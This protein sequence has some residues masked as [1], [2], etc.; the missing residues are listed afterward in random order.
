MMICIEGC[1]GIGKT[2]LAQKLSVDPGG[3]GIFEEYDNNPFLK[4]FY[5]NPDLF[6]FHVQTTFLCLQSK[7]FLKASSLAA[8]NNVFVDF[9]PIKSQIFSGIV[10]KNKTEYDIIQRI[11]DRL[12]SSTGIKMLMVY[13]HAKPEII[14]ERIR[15]RN[16]R[17]TPGI[18]FPYIEQIVER[19]NLYFE[20]Y[21]DPVLSIDMN[22]LDFVN[23]N[24]DWLFVKQLITD[25]MKD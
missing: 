3:Y 8:S 25:K 9:H 2:T 18:S 4:D 1:I 14:F 5:D 7:Q 19:Y 11:Y 21:K 17:F 10:I 12:F 24:D 22:N 6:A 15:L 13:L 23:S 20:K 16:D